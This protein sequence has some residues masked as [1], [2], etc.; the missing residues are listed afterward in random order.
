[1]SLREAL[2]SSTADR[3]PSR[4]ASIRRLD[5][6]DGEDRRVFEETVEILREQQ[7]AGH[8]PNQFTTVTYSSLYRALRETGY[9]VSKD[10]LQKH[11]YGKCRCNER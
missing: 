3:D 6:M 8:L 2:E 11:V 9:E 10:G 7:S 5:H 4:C 1:M